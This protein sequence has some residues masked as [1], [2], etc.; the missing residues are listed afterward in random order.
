MI[1]DMEDVPS[2]YQPNTIKKK[3]SSVIVYNKTMGGVDDVDKILEPYAT[4][5]KSMKWYKKIFFHLLDI[6]V[7]NSFNIY[8]KI[9]GKNVSYKEF[10]I[11]LLEELFSEHELERKAIGRPVAPIN[12]DVTRMKGQHFPTRA[13]LSNCVFCYRRG[14]RASTSFEC[15]TCMVKLCIDGKNGNCFADFHTLENFT[16]EFLSSNSQWAKKRKSND[17]SGPRKRAKKVDGDLVD[18][19]E[20]SC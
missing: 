6:S 14:I 15:K 17:E 3:P 2:K 1:H 16:K 13:N 5:R 20:S 12:I 19:S 4:S 10:L 9:T 18:T 8:I 11:M 7:Y